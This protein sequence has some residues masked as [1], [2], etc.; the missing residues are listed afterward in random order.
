MVR[1]TINSQ[2][3]G[4]MSLTEENLR[5]DEE[6]VANTPANK[7]QFIFLCGGRLVL[8]NQRLVFLPDGTSSRSQRLKVSLD[9]ASI[10]SIQEKRM[11]FALTLG[12]RSAAPYLNFEGLAVELTSGTTY[13]FQLGEIRTGDKA[14]WMTM[15]TAAITRRN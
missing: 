2:I 5:T 14:R 3:V 11:R 15:L 12:S 6:I 8:T 1:S 9:L 10:A 13:D 4:G 7:R